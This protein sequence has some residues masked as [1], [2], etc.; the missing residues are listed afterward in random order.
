MTVKILSE[1]EFNEFINCHLAVVDCWAPWCRPCLYL[2]PVLEDL[3]SEYEGLVSFGKINL[4]E[5]P[6]IASEFNIRAIPTILIFKD[7]KLVYRIVGLATK[8]FL[9]ERILSFLSKK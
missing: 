6:L 2:A 7:G 3:S 4:E 5:N 8:A 9:E 1:K